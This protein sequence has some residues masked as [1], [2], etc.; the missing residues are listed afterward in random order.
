[1]TDKIIS[2]ILGLLLVAFF[3][4]NYDPPCVIVE[5]KVESQKN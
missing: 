2:F 5:N 1:M 4:L 3:Y